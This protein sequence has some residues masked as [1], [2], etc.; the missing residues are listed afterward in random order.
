M[1]S[2]SFAT[3][4]FVTERNSP[5]LP[6]FHYMAI[7]DDRQRVM[8]SAEDLTPERSE[9]LAYPEAHLLTNPTNPALLGEVRA[10]PETAKSSSY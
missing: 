2:D 10:F 5:G 4:L 1:F 6:R 7:A 3:I 8:P 9:Q